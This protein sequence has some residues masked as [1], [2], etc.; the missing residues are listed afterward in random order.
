MKTTIELL[1]LA[2]FTAVLATAADPRPAD[3]DAVFADLDGVHSPGCALGVIRDGDFVYRQG[4]GMGSI[5][6]GMPIAAD[7]VFYVG[8]ISKQFVASSIIL[9]AEQGALSL[10]DNVRDHI[11]ELPDY[12]ANIT[13]GNL[14]HH[15]SGLRDYLG[16]LRLSGRPAEDIVTDQEIVD[17]IVRQKALNFAP[18]SQYLYSNSGYFLLA[19]ILKRATGQTLRAFA[20]QRIFAPLHMRDTRFHDD[21]RRIVERRALAYSP[22]ASGGFELDWS[23]NFDKVGSGGLL[24]TIND[25]LAWNNNFDEPR[26]GGP[27]FLRTLL[28]PGVL[29]DGARQ[30]YAFGLRIGD[31]R[32]L[33]TVSHSGAMFGFRAAYLRFP[34]QHFSAVAFCNLSTADPMSRIERVAD[35]YLEAVY[36]QKAGKSPAT[37]RNADKPPKARRVPPAVIAESAGR[38]YS[39]ELDAVYEFE[40]AS[41]ALILRASKTWDRETLKPIGERTFQGDGETFTFDPN[42][43]MTLDAGRVVGIRFTKRRSDPRR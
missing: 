17:L 25:F 39:P 23:S 40:E 9:A 42:G 30:D 33:P 3:I 41:G 29:N 4:Y 14:I 6:H 1:V 35:L 21:R 5:E 34:A 16:L 22:A 12:G 36:P 10:D 15:T 18:G 19:E 24:T 31:R 32:G 7:T 20:A 13:I 43:G 11:P 37:S 26:I 38:Y 27:D 28:T 8:S 2:A